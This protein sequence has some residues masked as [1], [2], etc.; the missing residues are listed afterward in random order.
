MV[1]ALTIKGF[2]R[3]LK[4]STTIEMSDI[5]PQDQYMDCLNHE[6]S[7]TQFILFRRTL[8]QVYSYF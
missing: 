3:L 6:Y 7:G 1:R 2:G 8:D 5:T 4:T